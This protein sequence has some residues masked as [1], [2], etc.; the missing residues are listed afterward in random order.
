MS[1]TTNIYVFLFGMLLSFRW[2]D[3]SLQRR[4][5]HLLQFAYHSAFCPDLPSRLQQDSS[6]QYQNRESHQRLCW[7]ASTLASEEQTVGAAVF[8]VTR[9]GALPRSLPGT[10]LR[11]WLRY[12][13]E[14]NVRFGGFAQRKCFAVFPPL[15][16]QQ[17]PTAVPSVDPIKDTKWLT[18]GPCH[19]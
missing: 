6:P 9:R 1:Q 10:S 12:Q 7:G 13:C 15:N 17:S 16:V 4:W 14:C 8:T 19:V 3:Q 11:T 5:K 18:R 2:K